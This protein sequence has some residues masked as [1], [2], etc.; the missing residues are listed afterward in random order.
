MPR[1]HLSVQLAV[2]LAAKAT[3]E[4]TDRMPGYAFGPGLPK[5]MM[6][7]PPYTLS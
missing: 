6:E 7:G 4:V 2:L 1:L 3:T 5:E